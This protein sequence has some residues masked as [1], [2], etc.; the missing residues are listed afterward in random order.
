MSAP[1]THRPEA[2]AAWYADQ[3]HPTVVACGIILAQALRDGNVALALEAIGDTQVALGVRCA[4]ADRAF[5]NQL[6][7]DVCALR[8]SAHIRRREAILTAPLGALID[9][10]DGPVRVARIVGVPMHLV[11]LS[12][13]GRSTRTD[14]WCECVPRP[15]MDYWVRY[16]RWSSRG[17]EAH[18]YLCPTCRSIL[19]AG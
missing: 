16:E 14:R 13:D 15:D 5:L 11:M 19:Q 3:V 9:C 8:S 4:P 1:L 12:A 17:R 10:P 2:I 6:Y 18:G 7:A